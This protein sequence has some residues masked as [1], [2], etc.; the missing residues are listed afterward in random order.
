MKRTLLLALVIV[1]AALLP[2]AGTAGGGSIAA[3]PELLLGQQQF[4]DVNRFDYWRVTMNAGDLLVLDFGKTGGDV[5]TA[6]CMI[7]PDVTD[8]T[9]D[10]AKC[11]AFRDTDTTTQLRFVAT[12][13]GRWNLVFGANW[14]GCLLGAGGASISITWDCTRRVAYEATGSVQRYTRTAVAAPSVVRVGQSFRLRGTTAG[15]SAGIVEIQRIVRGRWTAIGT[16]QLGRAGAFSFRTRVS[17]A[18]A[19]RFR[20]LYRGDSEHRP[21]SAAITVRAS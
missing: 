16:A 14:Y 20:A 19:L 3:A 4:S 10:S 9:K 15:V 21:S 17:R 2:A 7:L 18:G 1:V 11:A 12:T 6:A 8:Y 5:S 13:S